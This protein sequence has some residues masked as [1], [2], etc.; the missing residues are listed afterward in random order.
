MEEERGLAHLYLGS[1]LSVQFGAS[2]F[3]YSLL[4]STPYGY[5]ASQNHCH[6][7]INSASPPLSSQW[8]KD[9]HNGNAEGILVKIMALRQQA[10]EN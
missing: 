8:Y 3:V 10:G 2:Y 5:T 4:L 6:L 9:A 7:E 1:Y